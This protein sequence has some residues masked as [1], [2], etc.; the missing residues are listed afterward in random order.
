MI[1]PVAST[2]LLAA[3]LAGCTTADPRYYYTDQDCLNRQNASRVASL[4]A[5]IGLGL[6]GVPGG[7]L[8]VGLATNPRCQAYHLTPE[9]RV[10]IEREM[11][12]ERLRREG[13]LPEEGRDGV[14]RTMAPTPGARPLDNVPGNSAVPPRAD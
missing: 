4:A 2:C 12:A 3:L 11:R 5:G 8:V 1:R 9:G 14:V 7:G 6:V 13:R 10:R